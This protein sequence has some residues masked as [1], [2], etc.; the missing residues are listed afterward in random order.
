MGDIELVKQMLREKAC[1]SFAMK[2]SCVWQ[3]HD[4]KRNSREE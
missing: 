3:I 4:F 1:L 2:K